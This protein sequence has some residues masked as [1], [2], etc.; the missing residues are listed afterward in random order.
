MSDINK[1]LEEYERLW[2][3]RFD[4]L[5]AYLATLQTAESKDNESE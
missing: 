5:D 3:A 4:R 1:W 2:N